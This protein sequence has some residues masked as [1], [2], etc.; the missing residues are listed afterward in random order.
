MIEYPGDLE[1]FP[2]A[3]IAHILHRTFGNTC[4]ILA[5][6]EQPECSLKEVQTLL[7]IYSLFK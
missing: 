3:G 7:V 6:L 1:V 2:S 5:H 4:I